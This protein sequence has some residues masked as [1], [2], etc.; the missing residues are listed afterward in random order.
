MAFNRAFIKEK[1]RKSPE[2]RGTKSNGVYMLW[3]W[4]A[5]EITVKT[6]RN[7]HFRTKNL[8]KW[9]ILESR[10]RNEE[11]GSPIKLHIEF[12]F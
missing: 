8:L 2:S 3:M 1:E 10:Q 9:T 5:R 11:N 4:I 12:Y 7:F 6:A